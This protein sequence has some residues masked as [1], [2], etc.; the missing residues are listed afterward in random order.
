METE[1]GGGGGGGR[2][3]KIEIFQSGS[4]EGCDV[5]ILRELKGQVHSENQRHLI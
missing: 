2:K 4:R 3:V 1:R 5:E